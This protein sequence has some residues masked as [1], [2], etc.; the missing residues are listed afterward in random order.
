MLHFFRLQ[1]YI[2]LKGLKCCIT[3]LLTVL[4][5][6]KLFLQRGTIYKNWS[7]IGIVNLSLKNPQYT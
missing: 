5:V 3:L 7:I 1:M 2:M 4:A 6:D